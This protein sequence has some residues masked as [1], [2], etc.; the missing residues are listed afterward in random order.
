MSCNFFL[1]GVR[2][3]VGWWA[4]GGH[5]SLSPQHLAFMNPA[6]LPSPLQLC[7]GRRRR[8]G[9]CLPFLCFRGIPLILLPKTE[10]GRREEWGESCC[11]EGVT[12]AWT[13]SER[14]SP[15]FKKLLA[16]SNVRV[17]FGSL[18]QPG[19]DG[20]S[21]GQRRKGWW[22]TKYSFGLSFSEEWEVGTSFG[23]PPLTPA[24]V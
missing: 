18:D 10:E 19:R 20:V 2:M 11:E 9:E 8:A 24:K 17:S 13:S 15:I 4:W 14:P 1:L 21:F 6:D 23:S 22:V 16:F 7:Q 5:C 3:G 12:F